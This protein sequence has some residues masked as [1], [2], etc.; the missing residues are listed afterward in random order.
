MI[1][2]IT[3][4]SGQLAQSYSEID[5]E[6]QLILLSKNDLDITDEKSLFSKFKKINPDIIFHFAS[7]TRRID[8][9][10][11]KELAYKINVD[12]TKNIVNFC[13]KFKKKL[14]FIST[15]EVFSGN[16]RDYY[17][18]ADKPDPI[19]TVG[20]T[21]LAAEEYIRRNLKEFFIVRTSWLYSKW[22]NN[23]LQ[24]IISIA[25]ENNEIS[26]VTDE[27]GSPTY[28][29]DLAK[30]IKDLIKTNSYGI[31]HISNIGMASRYDFG[32]KALSI[33]KL[34]SIKVNKITIDQFPAIEMPPK[35]SPL[36]S[37]KLQ[38]ISINLNPWEK[39]LSD[40][41][42]K[43]KNNHDDY[44]KEN[45]EYSDFL[46][47]HEESDYIKTVDF[48]NKLLSKKKS[49][50]VLE[51]G[52]GT[53][54]LLS[55][56]KNEIKSVGIEISRSSL[57]I[58]RQKKL[59]VYP[60]NGRIFPFKKDTFDVVLSYNVLEHVND[61]LLFLEEQ[62]RV[63]KKGGHMLVACPNFLSFSNNYHHRTKGF[64]RKIKNFL[65]L[66]F[67]L[68]FNKVNFEKMKPII[69][70]EFQPDDDAINVTNPVQ[71][72]NWANL[73]NLNVIFWSS[74]LKYSN[75]KIISLLD[76]TPFKV[77]LGACFI[78]MRKK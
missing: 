32:K 57:R 77:G 39:S 53:G 71:L 35:F 36:K 75:N 4:G 6:N 66:L 10:N 17:F 55:L 65:I 46:E 33:L 1:I 78:I 44:Y 29:I 74:Q 14:V 62:K 27:V 64:I 38:K 45:Q 41:L 47:S 12:G 31:F 52:C 73:N 8:C 54:K 43:Q 59:K 24:T 48:I 3:G 19:T 21:K 7:L 13:K 5:K 16:K 70:K 34:N 61:P 2:A 28:S 9:A 18:E 51:V 37:S 30:A 67:Y 20:K 22:S 68:A 23:F 42:T 60:Y 25:K 72:I 58:A 11:N 26:L 69:R 56:L 63:L 15:N 50:K 76:K 49:K 40:F